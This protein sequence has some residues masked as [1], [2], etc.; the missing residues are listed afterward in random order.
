MKNY[1]LSAFADE[2]DGNFETQLSALR[3]FF[4]ENI[5]LRFINGINVADLTDVQVA[6]VKEM[7]DRFGIR[8]SAIG[9]PIGKIPLDGDLKTHFEKAERLFRTANILG[10][11]NIRCFSFYAPAGKTITECREEVLAQTERL[12]NMADHYAV[13]LCHEN[14]AGIYG[15]SPENCLDLLQ[16]F[17]GRL[18]AVFDMGNFVLDGFDP[19]KAMAL[20]QPYIAYFHIKDALYAGAI[21]PAGKGEACIR[22]ILLN[23]PAN[24]T[25]VTLEPHLQTFS[26]L[27]ALVGKTFENPYQYPDQRAAFTDAVA[28]IREILA[29]P[30]QMQ[31]DKLQ[32]QIYDNRSQMGA[33]A[34][35]D[36]RDKMLA[37]LA[38]KESINMI[39][40]AAPSQND[41][42]AALVAD[43]TIPWNRVNAFHMDEY[44]DLPASAPQGFANFLRQHLFE[45]VNFRSINCLNC[46]AADPQAECDRY[47]SLL[48]ANPTDVVVLGIGENGHIAFNDPDVADFHDS[49]AVK[50]VALDAI[51]RQQQVNDGCFGC[52]D[53]VPTH[54]MTLTVPTLVSAPYLFCIVPG[55]TKAKA[56]QQ[57]LCG[58]VSENC[59]ASVLRRCHGA[60][61][62]LDA[63]SGALL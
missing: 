3:R 39:F 34:A 62:Y 56:V 47:T 29:E 4:I 33:A 26:G 12:L 36:I 27:N 28:C 6:E 16:H 15:E 50:I 11:Q 18:K 30:M 9:S 52:I 54:A 48:A 60:K 5:E 55:P 44:V 45:K 24:Q 51:C 37:L 8:V 59:P 31:I 23:Y 25:V 7:L 17:D 42:L 53:S 32:V 21:V 19:V 38:Q 2:Y 22:E 43:P 61:L 41:V 49:A 1:I 63:D 14:E 40:A 20:L 58:P 13:T 35:R 57:T 46:Q 10:V